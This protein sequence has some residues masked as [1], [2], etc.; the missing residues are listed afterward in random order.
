[1]F[2]ETMHLHSLVQSAAS[3]LTFLLNMFRVDMADIRDM[4]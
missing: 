4:Y 2:V 3:E 1:M